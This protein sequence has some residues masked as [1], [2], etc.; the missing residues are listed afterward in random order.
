[1]PAPGDTSLSLQVQDAERRT[2]TVSEI[3]LPASFR[4]RFQLERGL[5]MGA[6]GMVWLATDRSMRRPVAIKF[7]R[8]VDDPELLARFFREG[9][10]MARVNHPHVVTVFDLLDLDGH[11]CLV[12]E[13]LDGGTLRERL[14][15]AGRLEVAESARIAKECLAGLAACHAAGLVHRDLKPSNVLF[16]AAGRACVA[17]LGLVRDTDDAIALTRT[18]GMVGT[19]NYMAPELIRGE[20]ATE[21]ADLYAMGAV[22]Y[23]MLAGH[24]PFTGTS[25]MELF[26]RVLG[27]VPAPLPHGARS[28]AAVVTRAM[29][30]T[31]ADRPPSAL[32]MLAQVE[33]VER[34]L[35]PGG[36]ASSLSRRAASSTSDPE[37]SRR[38]L[39]VALPALGAVALALV[40]TR[41]VPDRA[42]GHTA[43]TPVGAA[44][45]ATL[46]PS[47]SA[48]PPAP[49]ARKEERVMFVRQALRE[50]SQCL[51]RA[52]QMV[53]RIDAGGDS[54]EKEMSALRA[55]CQRADSRLAELE[56]GLRR[57]AGRDTGVENVLLASV[58]VRRLMLYT[59]L[60]QLGQALFQYT[61]A[62]AQK[63]AFVV[64][65]RRV[66]GGLADIDRVAAVVRDI[67][68][69]LVAESEP[70]PEMASE[71][72]AAFA[73]LRQVV[74][75]LNH[76][77]LSA[78]EEARLDREVGKA[79]DRVQRTVP[80]PLGPRLTDLAVAVWCSCR[81][82]GPQREAADR[83]H[84]GAIVAL[85]PGASARLARALVEE[86]ARAIERAPSPQNVRDPAR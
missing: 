41:T 73:L 53:R 3:A 49:G 10:A 63:I 75:T 42:P 20:S 54:I 31:P 86:R 51:Y 17:D 84:L 43:W 59:M 74:E 33:I 29:S 30:K 14:L 38:L 9:R 12:T 5:G 64:P 36:A 34:R 58:T 37:V 39:Q 62:N 78:V 26:T 18:G 11:P 80:P 23:E 48:V 68:A 6:M 56:R 22:L 2:Q 55:D 21:A 35:Q 66:T 24:T 61:D 69:A 72:V 79:L 81:A 67:A 85:E 50:T 65:R 83:D 76:Y 57:T 77:A 4:G 32:A 70:I 7:L 28:L 1:M 13:Y 16:D 71:P 8:R 15:G 47:V 27:E 19:P 44:C 46:A 60:K 52:G 25:L 40:V 45:P 82:R